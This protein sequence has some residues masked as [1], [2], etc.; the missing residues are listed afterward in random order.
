MIPRVTFGMIVLNGQPFIRHNLGAIYPFAHQIIVVEGACRAAAA[1]STTSGHSTDGT[2]EELRA[3]VSEEDREAK[4]Q[5]V[6]A[7]DEGYLDGFWPEKDQMSQA[8]A[9]RA[10]GNYLWQI[11]VDEFYH[12]ADLRTILRMLEGDPGVSGMA[13][14]TKPFWGGFD[15]FTDGF[16]LRRGA[17]DFRRLFA[18]GPGYSY[19]THRP[20]TV[21]DSRGQ[22]VR[23][24]RFVSATRLARRGIYMYHYSFVFPFQVRAKLAYYGELGP[25]LLEKRELWARNYQELTNPFLIDD[26]S[27]E[28]GASWLRRYRGVHPGAIRALRSELEEQGRQSLFRPTGDIERLVASSRY[29]F[30]TG[31]LTLAS[32]IER[33]G[34]AT[35]TMLRRTKRVAFGARRQKG[36]A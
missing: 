23:S 18:W 19:V 8:Y 14:R 30:E 26:T 34:V 20:P 21:V 5:I 28:G 13:F 22:D 6:T 32:H 27:V 17:R 36:V 35:R 2:L 3:F 16:E 12:E 24:A 11:D 33:T 4:V 29:R 10:T 1:L 15:Y 7:E 9:R 31:M 25:H